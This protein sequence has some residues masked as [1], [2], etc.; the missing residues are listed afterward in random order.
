MSCFVIISSAGLAGATLHFSSKLMHNFLSSFIFQYSLHTGH[1]AWLLGSSLPDFVITI[2]IVISFLIEFF[3]RDPQK[4]KS[5]FQLGK[6]D[7]CQIVQ[8]CEQNS[9]HKIIRNTKGLLVS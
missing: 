2:L 9:D 4:S 7:D 8:K 3:K 1:I 6:V 5:A